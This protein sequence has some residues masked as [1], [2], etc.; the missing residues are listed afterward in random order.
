M[1]WLLNWLWQGS[2][3]ALAAT[4]II[5]APRSLSATTRYHLWWLTLLLV[6]ALPVLPDLQVPRAAASLPVEASRAPQPAWSAPFPALPA[7]A[8]TVVIVLWAAWVTL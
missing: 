8:M 7:W 3:V 2:V 6:L 5:Q 1:D 4:A